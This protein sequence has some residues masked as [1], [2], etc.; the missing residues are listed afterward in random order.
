MYGLRI[1]YWIS[2]LVLFCDQSKKPIKL[3]K[4]TLMSKDYAAGSER[5]NEAIYRW[6]NQILQEG[7][8]STD[9]GQLWINFFKTRKWLY[10]IQTICRTGPPLNINRP[11]TISIVPS[12]DLVR[13]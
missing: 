10:F 6:R 8:R 5:V 13:F 4:L 7:N 3:I 11:R 9:S 1:T 12:L 2:E